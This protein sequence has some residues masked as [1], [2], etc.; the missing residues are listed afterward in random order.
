M[1]CEPPPPMRISMRSRPTRFRACCARSSGCTSSAGD[2][3]SSSASTRKCSR[4]RPPD[5]RQISPHR[6]R[7]V[8]KVLLVT[9]TFPPQYDVSARRAAKVC[10]YL[11]SGGWQ[12]VVLTKDWVANVAAEDRRT[13]RV[14]S[15]PLA[16]DELA[17]VNVIHTP[18]RT[19]DNALRR[20]HEQ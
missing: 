7:P 13:Y 2:S 3:R 11:P 9:Y 14:V 17:G 6:A 5:A 1:R 20:L 15:H 12:P 4:R 10:K 8:R 16:L 18:Y 19:R